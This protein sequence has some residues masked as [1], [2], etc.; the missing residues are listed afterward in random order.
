MYSRFG[1]TE[2]LQKAAGEIVNVGMAPVDDLLTRKST[3]LMSN[4]KCSALAGQDGLHH[5]TF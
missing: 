1:S 2:S 5:V 4:G 3:L